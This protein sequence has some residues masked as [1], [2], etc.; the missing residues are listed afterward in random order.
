MPKK[1]KLLSIIL[2]INSMALAQAPLLTPE[3]ALQKA[4]EHNFRIRIEKKTSQTSAIGN[5]WSAAGLW[6]QI[7]VQSQTGIAS[8]D[9]EQRL[10]NGTNIKRNDAILRNMAAGLSINWRIFNGMQMFATKKR[11]EELELIGELN[12]KRQVTITAYEVLTA[13]YEIVQL[14]QQIT[15]LR[16]TLNYL[17]ERKKIAE[18][19]FR[20]GTSPK[21]DLLQAQVDHNLQRANLLT[22]DNNLQ[23]AKTQFNHLLGRKPTTPFDVIAAPEPGTSPDYAGY[24]SQLLSKNFDLLVAQ[25]QMMVLFQQKRELA[26]QRLPVVTLNGNLNYNR[27]RNDAGFNLF[28]SNF[29]PSGSIGISIPLFNGGALNRELKVAE[30]QIQQQKITIE[31]LQNRLETGLLNAYTQYRYAQELATIET[32]NL[33]LIRENLQIATERFRKLSITSLEL[34]Q[35]QLDYMNCRSRL[36]SAQFLAKLAETEMKLLVGDVT[37]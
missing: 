14:K 31:E 22:L 37:L 32:M 18:D 12:F 6:P 36:L 10:A 29:G 3:V 21:T 11:L 9:L 23:L 26:L 24:Q 16:E 34:R 13:Y 8:N 17:E 35:I 2:L 15:A 4:L 5:S 25:S 1:L 27:N 19:R 28:S 20:I 7:T 33:E 30:L